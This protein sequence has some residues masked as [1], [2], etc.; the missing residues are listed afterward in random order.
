[1]MVTHG[2]PG[3]RSPSPSPVGRVC[4]CVWTVVAFEVTSAFAVYVLETVIGKIRVRPLWV[5]M[6]RGLASRG[7]GEGDLGFE[8]GERL[9]QPEDLFCIEL[10][11][12]VAVR[13]NVD[14]MVTW[15]RVQTKMMA[16]TRQA[17]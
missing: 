12:R 11:V 1:M 13:R 6:V 5:I 9:V 2:R 8:V 10:A 16:G 4:V 3:R 7:N 17:N 14:E 15:S